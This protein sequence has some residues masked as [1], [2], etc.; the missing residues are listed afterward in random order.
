M[1]AWQFH[2]DSGDNYNNYLNKMDDLSIG[3]TPFAPTDSMDGMADFRRRHKYFFKTI[4]IILIIA[5]LWQEVV[6]AQGGAPVW[7]RPAALPKTIELP[8]QNATVKDNINSDSAKT[9]INIQ[10]A[11]SNLGAQQSVV[12]LLNDLYNKY[13]V[14]LV[15]I[16]GSKGYIDT[17]LVSA[18]PDQD[19]KQNTANELM[20]QGVISAGEFY[21]MVTDNPVAVYG[22][23]NSDLYIENVQSFR[24]TMDKRIENISRV[25]ALINALEGLRDH[26]FNKEIN[27]LITN[28]ALQRQG[29]I[30]FTE[31]WD[32][33]YDLGKKT[34]LSCNDYG[35]LRLLIDVRELEK[36]I[37]FFKA[38]KQRKKLI[39][40]LSELMEK[41]DIEDLVLASVSFKL[42][43]VSALD[44]HAKLV[45]YA[46]EYKV[47][48]EKYRELIKYV[49]YLNKYE[50]IDIMQ[51]FGELNLYE[52]SIKNE[53]YQNQSQRSLDR[54]LEQAHLLK[55]LFQIKLNNDSYRQVVQYVRS[56]TPSE[57]SNYIRE[58]YKKYGIVIPEDIDISG[59]YE[60]IPDTV[61][62]YKVAEQRNNAIFDNILKRMN[63]ENKN[64]AAVITGGFHTEGL[65][66]IFKDNNLSYVVVM[67]KYDEDAP[68]RPYIAVLTNRDGP[69]LNGIRTGDYIA[70]YSC[71]DENMDIL[72]ALG[73]DALQMKRQ[74]LDMLFRRELDQQEQEQY[75]ANVKI[76]YDRLVQQQKVTAEQAAVQIELVKEYIA[77]RNAE[78]AAQAVSKA[79][80]RVVVSTDDAQKVMESLKRRITEKDK[81]ILDILKRVKQSLKDGRISEDECIAEVVKKLRS[82]SIVITERDIILD[83]ELNTLI[84]SKIIVTRAGP[85]GAE[86]PAVVDATTAKA[87][88]SLKGKVTIADN[89]EISITP[90]KGD[91]QAHIPAF[92][93]VENAL[94]IWSNNN[95]EN[96]GLLDGL[97]IEIVDNL[98]KSSE[99]ERRA[100]GNI[101]LRINFKTIANSPDALT[102][103]IVPHEL[104]HL[105]I[106]ASST[107][108]EEIK[109]ICNDIR[110]IVFSKTWEL[111]QD[112]REQDKQIIVNYIKSIHRNVFG[113]EENDIEKVRKDLS[114]LIGKNNEEALAN[115]QLVRGI[116]SMLVETLKEVNSQQYASRI[117]KI[118]LLLDQDNLE[119]PLCMDMELFDKFMS[120]A[121]IERLRNRFGRFNI[122]NDKLAQGSKL[123]LKISLIKWTDAEFEYRF[124][125]YMEAEFVRRLNAV[126]T[127]EQLETVQRSLVSLGVDIENPENENLFPAL[128]K[129]REPYKKTAEPVTEPVVELVVEPVQPA[130]PEQET[131]EAQTPQ[132]AT[133][134]NVLVCPEE[135]AEVY[136]KL[137]VKEKKEFEKYRKNINGLKDIIT[138]YR[139][140]IH[141]VF[142]YESFRQ[143]QVPAICALKDDISAE[144][145]TGGGKTLTL[146]GA[147]L[148]RTKQTQ[149]RVI[150]M[151]HQEKLTEQAMVKDKMGELLSKCAV[152]VGFILSDGEGGVKGVLFEN[153]EQVEN[154]TVEDVYE[155]ADILYS[156]SDH[157]VHRY[158]HEKLG[159]Q[160]NNVLTQRQ[161]YTLFDEG[162]LALVFGAATP[163]VISSPDKREDQPQEEAIKI[164]AEVAKQMEEGIHFKIRKETK[165]IILTL[166]GRSLASKLFWK[167]IKEY[168]NMEYLD[169]DGTHPISFLTVFGLDNITARGRLPFSVE[170]QLL[171]NN[172]LK[173]ENFFIKG[174]NYDLVNRKIVVKDEYTGEQKSGMT[175]SEGIHQAIEAKHE[176][177]ISA[178]NPSRMSMTMPQFLNADFI[179]G[180]AGASGTME[181][182]R[183]KAIYGAHRE[184]LSI[185]GKTQTLIKEGH[186]AFAKK[187]DKI[188]AV[189][190]SVKEKMQKGQPVF[191]KVEDTEVNEYAVRIRD[192]FKDQDIIV[193]VADAKDPEGFSKAMQMAGY[194]NVITVVTNMAHRGIDVSIAGEYLEVTQDAD[195]NN[196]AKTDKKG[197]LVVGTK[198][199]EL[200]N[201]KIPGLH[202]IS[203]YLDEA[204]A[205][206]IQTQGRADRGKDEIQG[207]WEGM[208]SLDETIFLE[209]KEVLK[210]YKSML[211]QIIE[212]GYFNLFGIKIKLSIRGWFFRSKTIEALV[213]QMRDILLSK[214]NLDNKKQRD[215]EDKVAFYQNKFIR[216]LEQ[217]TESDDNFR[218]YLVSLGINSDNLNEQ[219]I[220]QAKEAVRNVIL[221]SLEEYQDKRQLSRK[222][223]NYLLSQSKAG[224]NQVFLQFQEETW[225]ASRLAVLY[226]K[227]IRRLKDTINNTIAQN[228]GEKDA[229]EVKETPESALRPSAKKSFAL[230]AGF[231]AAAS[232]VL[233]VGVGSL[234]AI[235]GFSPITSFILAPAVTFMDAHSAVTGVIAALTAIPALY[236]RQGIS[237][238]VGALD[239]SINE[240]M[241]FAVGAKTFTDDNTLG[242]MIKACFK[243]VS[244]MSLQLIA[245]PGMFAGMGSLIT[246][247][248]YPSVTV[249]GLMMP[250]MPLALTAIVLAFSANAALWFIFKNQLHEA[251][252]QRSTTSFQNGFNTF[253]RTLVVG[254]AV[255]LVLQLGNG[256]VLFT[257]IALGAVVVVSAI[258]ILVNAYSQKEYSSLTLPKVIGMFAGIIG[259]GAVV[260]AASYVGMPGAISYAMPA[261]KFITGG[262]GVGMITMQVLTAKQVASESKREGLSYIK[263]GLKALITNIRN[264][265][266]YGSIVVGVC[267]LMANALYISIF[268][269]V[270]LS[271]VFLLNRYRAEIEAKLGKP[272][273]DNLAKAVGSTIMISAAA[274]PMVAYPQEAQKTIMND[275]SRISSMSGN[276]MAVVD[277]GDIQTSMK[278][279]QQASDLGF[280]NRDQNSGLI[281]LANNVGMVT[282]AILSGQ[283]VKEIAAVI[284]EQSSG[285]MRIAQKEEAPRRGE[286]FFAPTDEQSIPAEKTT[287]Q[288]EKAPAQTD[289]PV[290]DT[291]PVEETTP[292]EDITPEED[293]LEVPAI[294]QA[295]PELE[296]LKQKI[297]DNPEFILN[298]IRQN[299]AY[300]IANSVT[301]M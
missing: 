292:V 15:G 71:F 23:E 115:K 46:K 64:I 284:E 194:A 283:D 55:E 213:S 25:D 170:M 258:S 245:G 150:I 210:E 267:W 300:R 43:Q 208:F 7:N 198:E 29:K 37:D 298:H 92:L 161:T 158:E 128:I 41:G 230:R 248:A 67:P 291:T 263:E 109:V 154:V 89:G 234:V 123:P 237:K 108:S 261:L 153:G 215:Y 125:K 60:A 99:I 166:K 277:V 233:L 4:S 193:N 280:F 268:T 243:W 288:E 10:D 110:N 180:F 82:K 152:K 146:G 58:Q 197:E 20:K 159:M 272:I 127:E 44:F 199:V 275:I 178:Q 286:K 132:E 190:T 155:Q 265:V 84:M 78:Q 111:F 229:Q 256:I 120:G 136:N 182:E 285:E 171:L 65:T 211:S 70:V 88:V 282:D 149:D 250:V 299:I 168:K 45:G 130:T 294:L 122:E 241:Q 140:K 167:K 264:I 95:L 212:K 269:G 260:M 57:I 96:M 222:K 205:F 226:D 63:S 2:K 279:I 173:A 186:Q 238:K 254:V 281:R 30:G 73:V 207:T 26:V 221:S 247:I 28:G 235:F 274:T 42:G 179:T 32:Y 174:E 39:D 75:V 94:R 296:K 13:D 249:S 138:E 231:T 189:L 118:Q 242:N 104:Q 143:G 135:D 141:E 126:G 184:V 202:V 295:D 98:T 293:I 62:F 203:A 139:N 59:I 69:Y 266:M 183:F 271:V 90:V 105:I 200:I 35:N 201:G 47:Q 40:Q 131:I 103:F 287:P 24:K 244:I 187:E 18:F 117:E 87:I 6:Q 206:Q 191:V 48:T 209:N 77:Q 228:L 144:F 68:E 19:A 289:E 5:F 22:V 12:S 72:T 52:R 134:E 137:T 50:Q 56:T 188:K 8:Y 165:E 297:K 21:S 38:E 162:D 177:S 119:Q 114:A 79:V 195:G 217:I 160:A 253:L 262:V 17:T 11:H 236:L 169:A 278:R 175:F 54:Y 107:I 27:I 220:Q 121:S 255:G 216:L 163:F 34:Q 246:A 113:I 270:S 101:A 86:F 53:I 257:S 66:N 192:M 91:K 251:R 83:V 51:I 97:T 273:T 172:A 185:T 301:E 61:E 49:E 100:Y 157:I 225:N 106:G 223:M 218:S 176:L 81:V 85:R 142:G 80:K 102:Y 232:I 252:H 36:Q 133:L 74:T 151:T 129:A 239:T 116:I 16:E 93:Q 156:K 1:R 181:I 219:Q 196:I 224:L 290:E 145:R 124:A 9:I 148:A 76:I 31:Q 164:T 3:R 214:K 240:F 112:D 33:I 14:S 276:S 259:V 147:A 227:Q 204:E